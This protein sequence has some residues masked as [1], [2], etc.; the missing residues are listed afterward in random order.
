M[1]S[2]YNHLK[3]CGLNDK[4]IMPHTL[5]HTFATHLTLRGVPII[6]VQQLLGHADLKT[7]MRYL[8]NHFPDSQKQ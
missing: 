1:A 3:N 6:I 5:R 7:T 8:H 4:G 2:F